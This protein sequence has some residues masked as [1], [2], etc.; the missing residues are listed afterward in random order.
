MRTGT[1]GPHHGPK[2]SGFTQRSNI[3]A[4]TT[5][6]LARSGRHFGSEPYIV[7]AHH[8]GRGIA[9]RNRNSLPSGVVQPHGPNS[10][11]APWPR[12]GTSGYGSPA[13][14]SGR[15]RFLAVPQFSRPLGVRTLEFNAD[16]SKNDARDLAAAAAKVIFSSGSA[17]LGASRCRSP[18]EFIGHRS[19]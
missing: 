11:P 19:L 15:L 4:Q 18:D 16:G 6:Q 8:A 9:R 12:S 14:G 10:I 1:R 5:V 7:A 2:P 13:Y 3:L 17:L